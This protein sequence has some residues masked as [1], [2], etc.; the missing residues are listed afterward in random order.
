MIAPRFEN[1]MA[2]YCSF[3]FIANYFINIVIN[4]TYYPSPDS[5][6]NPFAPGFGAKD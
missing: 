2:L 5:S 3:V 6:G 4:Y 1:C